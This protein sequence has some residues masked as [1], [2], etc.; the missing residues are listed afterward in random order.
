MASTAGPNIFTNQSR[1][2]PI[3]LNRPFRSVAELGHVFSD[4]PWKNLSFFTPES[5][6]SGLLDVFCIQDTGRDDAIVAGKVNLNTRQSPVLK[7]ILAGSYADELNS[8]GGST[9]TA[10]DADALA[11]ALVA[12]TTGTAAGQGPLANVSELVG[13][14]NSS[15][16]ASQGGIDGR[17]SYT[18]FT[19]DLD[20]VFT[21]TAPAAAAVAVTEAVAMRNIQRFREAPIRALSA[22]GTARVWNLMI[23]IVAQTGR[24]PASATGPEDFSV[25]GEKRL[26]VHIAIDRYTGKVID[27]SVEVVTE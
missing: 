18:G 8:A 13:R 20:T 25:E 23:D 19:A 11:T 16:N 4:T 12:R 1:S 9:I 21:A 6:D 15:V 24:Y 3:I 26:W 7:A 10:T 5:G 2:R 14:W 27:S 17:Q 22:N